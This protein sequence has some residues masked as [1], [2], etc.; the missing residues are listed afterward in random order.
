L[1]TKAT[2][3]NC[4]LFSP[5]RCGNFGIC[6]LKA[7]QMDCISSATVKN[8]ASCSNDW[9]IGQW[10]GGKTQRREKRQVT[11]EKNANV[12][13]ARTATENQI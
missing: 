11:T 10:W 12:H 8:F 5:P 7:T 6:E 13:S 1:P 2:Q 9:E 4:I 3:I